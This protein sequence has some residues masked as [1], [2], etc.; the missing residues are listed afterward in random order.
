MIS[1]INLKLNKTQTNNGV[2]ILFVNGETLLGILRIKTRES[3]YAAAAAAAASATISS[4]GK[5]RSFR[6]TNRAAFP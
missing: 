5:R 6:L 4:H 1:K 2:V 3:P